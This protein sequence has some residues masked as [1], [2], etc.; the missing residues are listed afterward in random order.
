ME[1][2]LSSHFRFLIWS[3]TL[4]DLKAQYKSAGLGF[5]WTALQPL[6][7]MVI[8]TAV[9]SY[10]MRI[11]AKNYALLVLSGLVPWYFH[12][13]CLENGVQCFVSNAP[14]IKKVYF[15]RIA[16]P[17]SI[18]LAN[19]IHFGIAVVVFL[20]IAAVLGT[21]PTEHFVLI[22]PAIIAQ[23]IFSLGLMLLT[24]MSHVYYRDTKYIVSTILQAWFYLSPVLYPID[25]IPANMQTIAK[26]NP[27]YPV[28]HF[29]RC[30]LSGHTWPS[31]NA[32]IALVGWAAIAACLGYFAYRRRAKFIADLV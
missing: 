19:L 30:A 31:A 14:L 21:Y 27:V 15:P 32:W 22:F 8:L 24:G 13:A 26:L 10:F 2:I 3:L 23:T 12:S 16:L 29:C 25:M 5:L 17:I 11:P 20:V 7:S 6:L 18:I 9:F 28:I 4:K 1:A